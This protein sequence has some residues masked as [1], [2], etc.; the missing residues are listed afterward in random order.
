MHSWRQEDDKARE[1]LRNGLK[2]LPSEDHGALNQALV[3]IELKVGDVEVSQSQLLDLHKKDPANAALIVPLLELAFEQNNFPEVEDWELKLR[4]LND[5][6]SSRYADYSKVRRLL[7]QAT[8]QQD[9]KFVEGIELLADLER[10]LPNSPRKK[11]LVN[12]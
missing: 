2:A 12:S 10:R 5:P 7:A 1:I 4:D 8:G 11:S 3:G 6:E 9:S